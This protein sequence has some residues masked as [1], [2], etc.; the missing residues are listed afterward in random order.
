MKVA[1]SLNYRFR[2]MLSAGLVPTV[3]GI[4]V[5]IIPI[6]G[7]ALIPSLTVGVV[8]TI[9]VSGLLYLQT[10]RLGALADECRQIVAGS[11]PKNLSTT[12]TD[13]LGDI[14]RALSELDSRRERLQEE[15]RR[16][17]Q[18]I[19]ANLIRIGEGKTVSELTH[20][21]TCADNVRHL[22]AIL[23]ENAKKF[24]NLRLRLTL[25]ARV[26][27]DMPAAI[28][29]VDQIGYI[30]YLNG[31]AE[32][33]FGIPLANC[34]RK[35]FATL[36]AQPNGEPDPFNRPILE[37]NNLIS[38]LQNDSPG[39]AV[40]ELAKPKGKVRVLLQTFRLAGTTDR[41]SYVLARDLTEEMY[42]LGQDRARTRELSIRGIWELLSRTTT[43]A[44]EAIQANTRLLTSEVKQSS[45]RT[46]MLPRVVALRQHLA[47]MNAYL[48]T[49]RWLN[50]TYAN[51]LPSPLNQEFLA[52]EPVR[53][54]LDELAL[55]LKSCQIEVT[56][57]DR[58][59][60]IYADAEWLRTALVG[61]LLHVADSTQ[62]CT[63]GIHINRLPTDSEP[64]GEEIIEY[65]I[66]D[67]GPSLSPRQLADLSRPFGD[68]EP[69]TFLSPATSGFMP[70]LLLAKELTRQMA[71]QLEFG[72]VGDALVIRMLL[73]SRVSKKLTIDLSSQADLTPIEELVMGWKLGVA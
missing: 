8:S 45:G 20:S 33:L 61:V 53:G 48:R 44:I 34:A 72:A 38:W 41:T 36:L 32:K 23:Q 7:D 19:A 65:K 5:G 1:E 47:G 56:V 58:G 15:F 43:E 16:V 28:L 3:M 35:P 6:W 73:P 57:T 29:T 63:V 21:V 59:G 10:S 46:T 55:R 60:W 12:R 66:L 39:E 40:V 25:T 51:Q 18:E 24:A 49:F 50:L 62:D 31:A 4:L 52:V 11:A 27:H 64:N 70:G 2:L 54:A 17:L 26:L 68:L 67:A 69:P 9:V 22:D 71:G 30:R 14:S 13:E 37:P 42:Q